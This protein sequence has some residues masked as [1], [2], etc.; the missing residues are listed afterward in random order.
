MPKPIDPVTEQLH[1]WPDPA[2][3]HLTQYKSPITQ[4]APKV[5]MNCGP[6]SALIAV[7][8]LGL[9]LPGFRGQQLQTAIDAA[10]LITKQPPMTGSK[11]KIFCQYL[12]PA[13]GAQ[14]QIVRTLDEALSGVKGGLPTVL[15]G[16]TRAPGTW[17][18]P[19][20]NKAREVGHWVCVSGYDKTSNRFIVN[21]PEWL[22]PVRVT[23]AQLR[24]F[25]GPANHPDAGIVVSRG[26]GTGRFSGGS[27]E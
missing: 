10:R 18:N 25:F 5:S 22:T 27:V 7:R 9:D 20:D 15:G 3:V 11:Q 26:D 24:N 23:Q 6:T 16:N 13:A 21:D 8:L 1:L 4:D 17:S 2:W 14:A 19:S 12:Q